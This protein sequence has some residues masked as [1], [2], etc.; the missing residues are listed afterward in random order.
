MTAFFVTATGTDI[1]KTFVTSG[2]IRAFKARGQNVTALKP[3]VSGYDF[4]QVQGSDPGAL[5]EA[6]GQPLTEENVAR[7]SPW[8]F[9]AALSPDMAAARE[10]RVIDFGAIVD[11]TAQ[12]DAD[13]TGILFVEGVGGIMVPLAPPLTTLDWMIALGLP[14]ILVTGNYLGAMSHT[15]SAV[16][17][18]TRSNLKCAALI[19]NESAASTVPLTKTAE[20][21]SRCLP[22]MPIICVP[23]LNEPSHPVFGLI[24]DVLET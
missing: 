17:V 4:G 24:A 23:R 22:E 1:G 3:V 6:L 12:A 10:G 9:G 8:R 21:L 18:L 19:V 11:F 7:I 15:L 13:H 16:D 2:L 14:V 20:T 5:L